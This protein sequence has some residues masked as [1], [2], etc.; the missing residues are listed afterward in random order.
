VG[1]GATG[2]RRRLLASRT[3]YR[4]DLIR[5]VRPRKRTFF[6]LLVSHGACRLGLAQRLL[7]TY[8]GGTM[9]CASSEARGPCHSTEFSA[10]KNEKTSGM[11]FWETFPSKCVY[12]Q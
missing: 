11:N 5:C 2:Q 6:S 12:E 1:A 10:P 3:G 7:S 9:R 8:G 4:V